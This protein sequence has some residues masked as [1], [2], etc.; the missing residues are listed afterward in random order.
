[1]SV[2]KDGTLVEDLIVLP[3]K[4]YFISEEKAKALKQEQKGEISIPTG[5]FTQK[6]VEDTKLLFQA[7]EAFVLSDATPDN[8]EQ[9]VKGY[10]NIAEQI[11]KQL[12]YTGSDAIAGNYG[13][14]GAMVAVAAFE[15]AEGRKQVEEIHV[16]AAKKIGFKSVYINNQL[17][18][19]YFSQINYLEQI[20]AKAGYCMIIDI[21]G[22]DT[23]VG[24]VSGLPIQES[25]RRFNI[26]GQDITR[27]CLNVLRERYNVTGTAYETIESWLIEGGT[28][29]GNAIDT[30][31]HFKRKKVNIKD[32][33]NTPEML[34]DYNKYFKKDRRFNSITEI[35][36]ESVSAVIEKS[37]AGIELLLG[38]VIVVGG[39]SRFGGLTVRLQRELAVQ[40]PE[41]K[42]QINVIVGEDPQ[43]ACVNGMRA[44]IT[45]KY[46]QPTNPGLA[47]IDLTALDLE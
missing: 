17:M 28:V 8:L 3:N 45:Q 43:N 1:C 30:E 23:K 25:F 14:W 11:D 10:Q 31:K 41:Y 9:L 39:A 33:L 40:F 2:M 21:G 7:D 26:G 47:Y 4:I 18:F 13:N 37:E 32:L 29:E 42:D 36:T 35:L 16:R 38:A 6:E 22:G 46:K 20:G 27:Y 12:S 44:L 24:G 19:D 34:F 15:T 5:L